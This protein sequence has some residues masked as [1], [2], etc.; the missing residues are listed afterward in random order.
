M[1]HLSRASRLLL[2]IVMMAILNG[3]AAQADQ[4]VR[5]WEQDGNKAAS[6]RYDPADITIKVGET[7][8]WAWEAD[9]K[10]SVTADNGSFDSGEHK[11]R[12]F[13]W[14]FKFTKAGDYPYSCTPHPFMTGSVKVTG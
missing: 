9:D 14:S 7:V 10:H 13:N 6:W 5:V 1:T 11:Q 3:P 12:G 4:R 2:A 8:T